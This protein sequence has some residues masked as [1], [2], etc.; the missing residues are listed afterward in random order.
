MS[1]TPFKTHAAAGNF[2]LSLVPSV[3]VSAGK[4]SRSCAPI[5]AFDRGSKY[6]S[7]FSL[8]ERLPPFG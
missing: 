4:P 3:C 2:G 8:G 1:C 6:E 7:V 5:Y